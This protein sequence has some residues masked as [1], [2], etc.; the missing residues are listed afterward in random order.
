VSHQYEEIIKLAGGGRLPTKLESGS[1]RTEAI[2]GSDAFH[3]SRVEDDD[4]L[5]MKK[6][7]T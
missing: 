2:Q 3:D 5:A 7:S 4:E 6:T 1:A